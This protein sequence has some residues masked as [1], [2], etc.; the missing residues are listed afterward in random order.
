MD[1]DL[2]EAS[3]RRMEKRDNLEQQRQFN[4]VL[5][6]EEKKDEG[7][8]RKGSHLGSHLGSRRNTRAQTNRMRSTATDQSFA[9]NQLSGGLGESQRY[10]A[11]A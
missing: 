9:H 6:E 4:Q 11:A 8:E 7:D 2:E 5:D 3:E 1:E 10:R